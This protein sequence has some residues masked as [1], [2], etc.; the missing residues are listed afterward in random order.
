MVDQ[1]LPLRNGVGGSYLREYVPQSINSQTFWFQDYFIL[2]K[3]I[4]EPK[5]LLFMWITSI[6]IYHLNSKTEGLASWCSG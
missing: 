5:E 4:E 6:Y 2:L 1:I 3:I